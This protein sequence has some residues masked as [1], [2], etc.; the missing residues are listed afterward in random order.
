MLNWLY[1]YIKVRSLRASII[2]THLLNLSK[3]CENAISELIPFLNRRAD[4]GWRGSIRGLFTRME[5]F[6]ECEVAVLKVGQE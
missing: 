4:V 5:K 1:F 6:G 2:K 3:K